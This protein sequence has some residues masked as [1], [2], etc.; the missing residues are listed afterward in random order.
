VDGSGSVFIPDSDNNRVLKEDFAHPS[1]LSFASTAVGSTSTDSPQTVT[2]VNDGNA[3]LT[4]PIP[5][6]GK[7]PSIA[8]NFTL[9]SS[10]TSACPV[11]SSGSSSPGTLAAGESCLLPI[12]FSPTAAGTL[13]GS[14]VLTDNALNVSGATQTIPL[15]GTG[16]PPATLASPT[17][18]SKLTSTSVQFAWSAVSGASAYDLHLSAVAPGGYDLYLSGHITGTST[19]ANNLPINGG[20]IYARLYTIVGGVTYY[21]DYTYTAMSATLAQMIYPA[22]GSTITTSKVWFDWTP[23]TGVTQYDLHL[24]AVAPGGYDLDASG[25]ITRTYKT[26]FSIPLSGETIYARLYSIIDG[27]VKYIDYTYKAK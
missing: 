21:N 18:G 4:F 26:V 17:P 14:L 5:S 15:S 24:S 7:N 8:A 11:V 6:T 9:N 20:K 27:E 13:S 25:P 1:S 3:A 22:P 2:L 23:G 10:A 19:T 16:L 12:S